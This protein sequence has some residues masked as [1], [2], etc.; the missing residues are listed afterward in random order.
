MLPDGR[1]INKK[2]TEHAAEAEPRKAYISTS[3]II[4]GVATP[5]Q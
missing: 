4:S 1:F 3:V 2:L 5:S